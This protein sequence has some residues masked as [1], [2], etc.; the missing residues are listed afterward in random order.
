MG[1]ASL[2]AIRCA[3]RD[4]DD[5]GRGYV[6]GGVHCLDDAIHAAVTGPR[7]FRSKLESIVAVTK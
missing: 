4:R 6:P 7:T 1:A 5:L 2:P 3:L